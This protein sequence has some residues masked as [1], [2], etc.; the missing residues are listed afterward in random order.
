MVEGLNAIP[1][2]N[3]QQVLK[4][5][6]EQIEEMLASIYASAAEGDL[7][8]QQTALNLLR[9]RAKLLGLY[10]DDRKEGFAVR[11]DASDKPQTTIHL[12]FV[13]PSPDR[14]RDDNEPARLLPPPRDVTPAP[15]RDYS[16]PDPGPMIDVAPNK[17]ASV[18]LVRSKRSSWMD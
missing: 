11:V 2:E 4:M 12:E 18:P 5:T 9:E 6:L 14:W 16:P 3:A 1:R 8:A 13:Q 7:P 10:P 17:P 15:R